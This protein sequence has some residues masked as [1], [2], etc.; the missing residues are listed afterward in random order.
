MT[1]V[2]LIAVALFAAM[3]LIGCGNKGP[4][5]LTP[6]PQEPPP[7]MPVA[8]SVAANSSI[9]LPSS[10]TIAPPAATTTAPPANA[11]GTPR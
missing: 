1:R 8:S 2:R 7:S 11:D 10:T 5:I 3:P 9:A 4:L 6:E